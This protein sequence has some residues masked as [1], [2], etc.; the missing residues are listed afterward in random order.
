[1][2]N[3]EWLKIFT[4]R[5]KRKEK[6][7]IAT[8]TTPTLVHAYTPNQYCTQ[9]KKGRGRKGYMHTIIFFS[10]LSHL[11]INKTTN[12]TFNLSFSENASLAWNLKVNY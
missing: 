1:M 9:R 10:W 4:V 3:D 12:I 2:P 7:N 8:L 5:L 11:E 6:A